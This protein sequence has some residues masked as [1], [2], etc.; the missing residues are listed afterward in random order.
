MFGSL[1]LPVLVLIFLVAAAII[2]IAGIYVSTTTDTISM[3]YGLGQALGGL[4][5]LSIVTNLPETAI[6]ISAA[7]NH[8]FELAIGNLLGGIAMQTMVLVAMDIFGVGPE[9]PLTST[10][11]SLVPVLEGGMVIAVLAAVVMAH[12]LPGTLMIWRIPP[13]ALA[14]TLI[15]LS[16]L[17]LMDKARKY[18]PWQVKCADPK[19]KEDFEGPIILAD[20]GEGQETRQQQQDQGKQRKGM[21][22]TWVIFLAGALATLIAGVALE[23]SSDA[24]ANQI[25]LSGAIFGATILAAATSLPEVSTG[26]KSTKS[27][28]Y[29]LA[30]SDI[31]GGNAFLPVLFLVAALISGQALLPQAK[32]TD[33]Y[34]SALGILMTIVYMYGLIFRP[35]KQVLEMGIDSL[36]VLIVYAIGIAGLIFLQQG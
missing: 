26:I 7:L 2:W 21:G 14:I 3:H 25:G 36:I 28:D 9:R 5:I 1:A 17:W 18:C 19:S 32:N 8:T 24:I 22:K 16:G 31:F 10:V 23:E 34:L 35:R 30:V 6:T 20:C 33:I 13:G 27:H 12:Q 11:T 4:V 29:E 15:W